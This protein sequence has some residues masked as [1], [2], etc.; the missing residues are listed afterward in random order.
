MSTASSLPLGAG[1]GLPSVAVHVTRVCAA[2][3]EAR[4]TQDPVERAGDGQAN[5]G[6]PAL[7]PC[8]GVGLRGDVRPDTHAPASVGTT[9]RAL[10][11]F[12]HCSRG[13]ACAGPPLQTGRAGDGATVPSGC[14][15]WGWAIHVGERPWVRCAGAPRSERF[16]LFPHPRLSPHR[17]VDP[18]PGDDGNVRTDPLNHP[19]WVCGPGTSR[20]GSGPAFGK[21]RRAGQQG[22]G[23]RARVTR[24]V[25]SP[26][27]LHFS[28]HSRGA[29]AGRQTD[30]RPGKR[31]GCWGP[32]H[33]ATEPGSLVGQRGSFSTKAMRH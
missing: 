18:N 7:R 3:E 4:I 22:R 24:L 8:W 15:G 28:Q 27:R 13:E 9:R 16:P 30:R 19:L 2:H 31:A 26:E 11:P 17:S 5:A 12:A 23:R 32:R 10:L 1:T 6:S 33:R 20:S 25:A 14:T 29:A 21:R